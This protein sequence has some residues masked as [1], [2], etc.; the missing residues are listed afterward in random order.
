MT[1]IRSDW[2]R[3]TA[4]PVRLQSFPEQSCQSHCASNEKRDEQ[5]RR[6]RR[7]RRPGSDDTL[8][9]S[10]SR[11]EQRS[12]EQSSGSRMNRADLMRPVPQ[13]ETDREAEQHDRR[14]YDDL[15]QPL[16]LHRAGGAKRDELLQHEHIDDGGERYRDHRQ[17]QTAEDDPPTPVKRPPAFR[18]NSLRNMPA[19]STIIPITDRFGNFATPKAKRMPSKKRRIYPFLSRLAGKATVPWRSRSGVLDQLVA[20]GNYDF[21]PEGWNFTN[22]VRPSGRPS[23]TRVV[24]AVA[25]GMQLDGS[26]LRGAI[27]QRWPKHRSSASTRRMSPRW[28]KTTYLN[29]L[30][31][32]NRGVYTT[33]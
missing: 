4:L 25:I 6:Q 19:H 29:E 27:V 16:R 3:V 11:Q 22:G 33:R 26:R 30:M 9:Y 8:A 18:R 10:R 32:P 13:R 12:A 28:S 17:Q 15:P 31:T 5:P 7:N 21:N 14:V 24:G 20:R 1:E 2:A 23:L